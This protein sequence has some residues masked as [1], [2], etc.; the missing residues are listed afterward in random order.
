MVVMC[1]GAASRTRVGVDLDERLSERQND[2]LNAPLIYVS[3]LSSKSHR[4]EDQLQTFR[5]F[6]PIQHVTS[7]AEHAG[8]RVRHAFIGAYESTRVTL[9]HSLTCKWR[10]DA[11]VLCVS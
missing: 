8:K 11:S 2:P 10:D 1:T 3:N 5:Q 9:I 4:H 7:T 6:G